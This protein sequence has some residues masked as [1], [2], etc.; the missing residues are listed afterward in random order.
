MHKT[1]DTVFNNDTVTAADAIYVGGDVYAAAIIGG[2]VYIAWTEN[3]G[4]ISTAR[5]SRSAYPDY[6]IVDAV[7][8]ALYADDDRLVVA[9]S[10]E[11]QVRWAFF[12]LP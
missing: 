10:N 8:V 3:N 9:A 5:L 4:S 7:D 2:E 12:D 1:F 6:E 11:T